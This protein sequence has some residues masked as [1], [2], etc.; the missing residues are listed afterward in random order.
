MARN[1]ED[2]LLDRLLAGRDAPSV[3]DR[4]HLWERLNAA[5]VRPRRSTWWVGLLPLG[6]GAAALMFFLV[7]PPEFGI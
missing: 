3:T 5:T 4:E 2:I 6:L 7:R 1:D